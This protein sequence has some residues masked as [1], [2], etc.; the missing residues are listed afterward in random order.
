MNCNREEKYCIGCGLC[1]SVLGHDKAK[2]A[3]NEAGFYIPTFNLTPE[4]QVHLSIFCP[5][6][7]PPKNYSDCIWGDYKAVGLGY[8]V[9]KEIR[10]KASSGGVLTAVA[11]YLLDK[12]I[13]DGIIQIGDGATPFAPEM[14]I[15]STPAQVVECC[16]SRYI[17]VLP[18]E[19]LLQILNENKDKKYAL[20]GRPCDIRG[21]RALEKEYENVKKQIMY[22]FSFFCA[23][24]PSVNAS[25]RMINAM[26]ASEKDVL[27]V[28]YRGNGWPGFSTVK[29]KKG[30]TYQMSYEQSWGKTLGRD[31]CLG[32]RHCYDGIGEQ[33]DVSCGDAWYL[34]GSGKVSFEE[35]EG[36]NVIFM[37]SERGAALIQQAVQV[38]WLYTENFQIDQL[39]AMQPYQYVRKA[40]LR[41]KLLAMRTMLQ[42][43]PRVDT[44][45][46]KKYASLIQKKDK[47]RMYFGTIKRI[48]QNKM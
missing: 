43:V 6:D 16:G 11:C 20:I 23:G 46:L 45:E 47:F 4:E 30:N 31:I 9:D 35:R 42:P 7:A 10:R 15:N 28:Q 34:D 38:G 8:A 5:V 27:S 36:R 12:Q 32:C 48:L 2:I 18:F 22:Y 25:K 39:K 44:S 26:G 1:T 29:T 24:T 3:Q 41:Y 13:V 40:Q 17:A 21:V 19:R 37:R 33:A 14:H